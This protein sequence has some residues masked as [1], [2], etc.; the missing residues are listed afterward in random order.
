M[1]V[2]SQHHALAALYTWGNNPRVPTGQE[3]GWASEPV[4]MHRLEEKSSA[5]VRDQTPVGQSVVRNYTD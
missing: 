2:S 1:G 3:A 5:S 4:W